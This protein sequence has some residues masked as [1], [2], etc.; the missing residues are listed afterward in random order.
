MDTDL[1]LLLVVTATALAVVGWAGR[2]RF[3]LRIGVGN[4]FRR[5]TQVAIVVAGL[6]IGT[7]IITSSYVIQSTFDY[8]IRSAVFRALDHVDELVYVVAPDGSR[9]PFPISVFDNLYA[10]R[11]SMP[12]VDALAPRVQLGGAVIDRTTGLFE[13]TAN[14]VGFDAAHEP[15]SFVREDGGSWDGSGLSPSEAVMNQKL[16][17]DLEAKAGDSLV[18]T[19]GGPR[20]LA[21]L[22][23]TIAAIVQDAGRGAWGDDSN[24][25]LPIGAL[26]AGLGLSGEVNLIVVSNVGGVAD[27][28]LRSDEAVPEIEAH[29]PTSPTF[30]VSKV[31]ADQVD[32]ATKNVQQLSQLFILLG[33]F[34]VVAGI[35]LIVNIFVMLAEERKGEMGVARALGMRRRNLV[36]S[37]IAEGLLYALSSAAIGTLAGLFIAGV[38]LWAFSQIFPPEAFGGVSF[39]LTWTPLDLISGF[40]IGFLITMATIVIASWRVSK[41][42]IVRA[43]RDIPEP[44]EQRSTARQIGVGGLLTVLG[45]VGFADAL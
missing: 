13:P 33:V 11:T 44:V 45:A 28:Y 30:T 21:Q 19:M 5:K 18:L 26:Q 20:G 15:G 6:L 8:T 25:F 12:T 38:I 43:I 34:T 31:K 40:S 35:L 7:S 29:V 27:G 22:N 39:V 37:F 23:L 1:A 9:S 17:G 3:P 14:V 36:Q 32:T 42:N 10:N 16:A 41:L 4:F 24:L 2:K